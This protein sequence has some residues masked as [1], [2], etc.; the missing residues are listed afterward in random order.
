M[1]LVHVFNPLFSV[2]YNFVI[3]V[4]LGGSGPHSCFSLITT[5]A[6]SLSL[7]TFFNFAPQISLKSVK[8]GFCQLSTFNFSTRQ[9]SCAD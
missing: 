7:A 2:F 4:D 8:L 3:Y 6:W 1:T 9:I 5:L